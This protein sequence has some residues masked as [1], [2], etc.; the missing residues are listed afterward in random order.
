MLFRDFRVKTDKSPTVINFTIS[1]VESKLIVQL[2][3]DNSVE[4]FLNKLIIGMNI[5]IPITSKKI[6]L[7]ENKKT[8]KIEDFLISAF[9]NI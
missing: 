5:P 3:N 2:K 1:S 7:K 9:N 4:E 6:V 8:I